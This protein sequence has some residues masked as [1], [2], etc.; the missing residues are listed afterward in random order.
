M[1]SFIHT[2]KKKCKRQYEGWRDVHV[3]PAQAVVQILNKQ[4]HKKSDMAAQTYSP[5]SEREGPQRLT[6]H[7]T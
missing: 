1:Q 6:S 5:E 3:L 2:G 4:P 7:P